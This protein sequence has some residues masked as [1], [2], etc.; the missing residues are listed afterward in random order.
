MLKTWNFNSEI[1]II[2]RCRWL[3]IVELLSEYY[4][5]FQ[6]RILQQ[7]HLDPYRSVDPRPP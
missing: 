1:M 6:K 3:T 5:K 7:I 2:Q 4:S